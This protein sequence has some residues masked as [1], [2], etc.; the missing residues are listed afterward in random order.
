MDIQTRI[1]FFLAVA[2]SGA[3]SLTAMTS[4]ML[5]AASFFRMG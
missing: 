5:G 1:V 3:I 2:T 4:L